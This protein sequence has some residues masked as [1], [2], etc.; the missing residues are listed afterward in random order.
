[1]NSQ[2]LNRLGIGGLDIGYILIGLVI[3]VLILLIIL[4]IILSKLSKLTKK[5]EEFMQGK[6]AKSLES[7][8]KEIIQDNKRNEELSE[9]NRKGIRKLTSEQE[10]CFQK[11]AI[12]KYDA[13]QEMGGRLSFAI[14]LLNKNNNGF[15][16]N[17]VHSTEGC[18]SYTK[19]IKDG[20]C[21]IPLGTEE[22][23]ALNEAICK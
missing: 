17:S 7:Q 18:Y 20:K 19:E 21:E 16:I 1:M 12:N 13:F 11:L 3:I 23:V 15:L 10:I 22:E 2:I 5:Y 8:I 9:V 4:I 6:D 14:A